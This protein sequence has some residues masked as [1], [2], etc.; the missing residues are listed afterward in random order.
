V[1]R[2]VS[3]RVVENWKAHL[4]QLRAWKQEEAAG[5]LE[6]CINELAADLEARKLELLTLGEASVECGY[7]YSSLEKR[8]RRGEI[9]NRG[10]KGS[11]RVRRGDLPKKAAASDG[12]ADVIL[13]IA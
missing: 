5:M 12:I 9:A 1:R 11:P 4:E 3:E 10:K 2:K 6:W 13:K 8:V 7:S